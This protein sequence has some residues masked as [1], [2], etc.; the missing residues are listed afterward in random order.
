MLRRDR[1]KGE[2]AKDDIKP[3]KNE[4]NKDEAREGEDKTGKSYSKRKA[5]E[6]K[7]EMA[8]T[9]L[10]LREN[11][12]AMAMRASAKQWATCEEYAESMRW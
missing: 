6:G 10:A 5:S 9:L 3:P 7:I 8:R 12:E 2:D 4:E 1:K 11:E